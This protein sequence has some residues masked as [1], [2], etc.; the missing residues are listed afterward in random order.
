MDPEWNLYKIPMDQWIISPIIHGNIKV[1]TPTL[2]PRMPPL[3][4][5]KGALRD[6]NQHCSGGPYKSPISR[7]LQNHPRKPAGL[8]YR[9]TT[10]ISL[11][12]KTGGGDTV[13][14]SD[15][16]RENQWRER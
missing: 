12:V 2:H 11:I 3:P 16:R 4:A 1:Y 6:Y 7:D 5:K 8:S 13:G 10:N 15:I 9:Y 14:G